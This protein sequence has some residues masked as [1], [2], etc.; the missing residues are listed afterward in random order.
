LEANSLHWDRWGFTFTCDWF[1]HPSADAQPDDPDFWRSECPKEHC[2][3]PRSKNWCNFILLQGEEIVGRYFSVGVTE[4]LR[5]RLLDPQSDGLLLPSSWSDLR[6]PDPAHPETGRHVIAE[7][8]IGFDDPD[9]AL[10]LIRASSW[11]SDLFYIDTLLT[12]CICSESDHRAAEMAARYGL[13]YVR[14]VPLKE[15]VFP[16]QTGAWVEIW[17]WKR[18]ES[19]P[20]PHA[21]ALSYL[22]SEPHE[23]VALAQFYQSLHQRERQTLLALLEGTDRVTIADHLFVS[24]KAVDKYLGGIRDKLYTFV[25]NAR[26]KLDSASAKAHLTP[27]L[28]PYV[29][30]LRRLAWFYGEAE[31][32]CLPDASNAR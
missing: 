3:F 8:F 26:P 28:L 4:T 32:K 30:T 2:L 22:P 7:F 21:Q 9:L 14:T 27:H 11:A 17:A 29:E 23:Q 24:T 15:P 31:M 12:Q 10:L 19:Q 16:L 20:E 5:D 25:E 6:V 13:Q 18:E 1:A